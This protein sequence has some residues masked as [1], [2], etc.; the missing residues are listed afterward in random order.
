M[1]VLTFKYRIRAGDRRLNR[2]AIACNQVWNCCVATQR[3]TERRRKGGSNC[4][5]P[6]AFDLIKLATGSA[7]DLGLHSD[8]VQTVC[9]QFAKSRDQHRRCALSHPL[10]PARSLRQS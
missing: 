2:F 3:E 8:T 5:W 10:E 7:A 9:R 1:S 4:S 6:T